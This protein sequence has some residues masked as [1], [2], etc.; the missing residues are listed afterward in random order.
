MWKYLCNAH[1]S[2]VQLGMGAK[3]EKPCQMNVFFYVSKMNQCILECD[4][5]RK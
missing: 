5:K 4:K 1:H 3:I 2:K